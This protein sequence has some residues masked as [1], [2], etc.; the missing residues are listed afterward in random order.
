MVK[1]VPATPATT[2]PATSNTPVAASP[3]YNSTETS[4]DYS[5]SSTPAPSA[6]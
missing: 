6:Q 2:A 5:G 3:V 4:I 1:N